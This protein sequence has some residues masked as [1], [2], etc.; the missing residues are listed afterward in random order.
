MAI[1]DHAT[2]QESWDFAVNEKAGDSKIEKKLFKHKHLMDEER[3][4]NCMDK[5][6]IHSSYTHIKSWNEIVMKVYMHK[7][8]QKI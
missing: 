5:T 7:F 1:L 8:Q 2:R 4:I 3:P 6:Y